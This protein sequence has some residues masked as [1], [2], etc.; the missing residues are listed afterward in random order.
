MQELLSISNM[1]AVL[2][3]SCNS[4]NFS[5]EKF[6]KIIM[7][8]GEMKNRFLNFNEK[9]SIRLSP[10]YFHHGPYTNWCADVLDQHFRAHHLR[11]TSSVVHKIFMPFSFEI[12]GNIIIVATSVGTD[13]CKVLNCYVLQDTAASL[14]EPQKYVIDRNTLKSV[15]CIQIH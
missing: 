13:F 1:I 8:G 9:I 7:E 3:R 15:L 5:K 6:Y 10:N 2:K 4:V 11:R 12:N 14:L